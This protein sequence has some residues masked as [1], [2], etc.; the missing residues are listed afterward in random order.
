[1]SDFARKAN[2]ALDQI[3]TSRPADIDRMVGRNFDTGRGFSAWAYAWG[4]LNNLG[5]LL[6]G[7]WLMVRE[8]EG[9]LATLKLVAARQC[10]DYADMFSHM[11][12][13]ADV[14]EMLLE[15]ARAFE[16]AQGRDAFAQDLRALQRYIVHMSFWVD[17]ELPWAEVSELVDAAWHKR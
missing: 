15:A 2:E 8:G 3:W 7:Y 6:Y 17:I 14:E 11:T 4:N 12:H 10:R 5:D 16:T 13:M 9:D 1:M